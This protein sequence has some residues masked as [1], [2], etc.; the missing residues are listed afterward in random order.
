ENGNLLKY[1]ERGSM[2]VNNITTLTFAF[3]E[4]LPQK[5]KITVEIYKDIKEYVIPFKVGNIYL[6]TKN[7]STP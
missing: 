6:P 3:E 2:S 5:G 4:E 1:E 7:F